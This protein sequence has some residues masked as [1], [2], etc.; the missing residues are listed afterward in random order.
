MPYIILGG[1]ILAALLIVRISLGSLN[2]IPKMDT[3]YAG[4]AGNQQTNADVYDWANYENQTLYVIAGGIG[5]SGKGKIA[6]QEA[7]DTIVRMFEVTGATKNPAFFFRQALHSAN[8]A[9][10]RRITDGTAGASV[11][12]AVVKDG[13]LYYVSVGN[14]RISVYRRGELIP[15]N[16]GHTIDVLA[17]NAFRKGQITRMEALATLKEKRLYSFVGHDG[18]RNME[19]FDVPVSL[20]KGDTIVMMTD[21]VYEFFSS[22]Q[23]EKILHTRKSSVQKARQVIEELEKNNHPEQDNAS[24]IISKVNRI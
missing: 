7:V 15:L 4:T 20:K 2:S 24:L 21:G 10:L 8:H 22:G 6:A 16:E 19:I 23:M 3:G 14:C 11:L 13:L 18:F 17:K 9:V 1:C 12:C 5:R